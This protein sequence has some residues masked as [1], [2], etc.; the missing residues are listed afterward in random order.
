MVTMKTF[1][2]Y[3]D[4]TFQIHVSR[5]SGVNKAWKE[6]EIHM[7]NYTNKNLLKNKAL[8]DYNTAKQPRRRELCSATKNNV[9][10]D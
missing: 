2:P 10:C 8:V 3:K 1:W 4:T 6:N 5:R 9:G 7:T